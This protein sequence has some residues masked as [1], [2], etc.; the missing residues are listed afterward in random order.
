MLD[1]EKPSG[2][3]PDYSLRYL[4]AETPGGLC[5]VFADAS[6]ELSSRRSLLRSC[7]LIGSAGAAAFLL[8]SVVL[9][10]W[11][12]HPVSEAWAAFSFGYGID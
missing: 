10:F 2:I 4:R 9:S 11:A 8:V 5:A 12:V 3:F 6:G 1:A 7:L